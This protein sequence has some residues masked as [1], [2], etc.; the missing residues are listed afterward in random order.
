MKLNAPKNQTNDFGKYK[1]RSCE[2][3]YEGLKKVLPGTGLV[4]TV[5]DDL[6]IEP[7]ATDP[8]KLI[9][10]IKAVA[11][12][13]DGSEKNSLSSTSFAQVDQHKG[14][15]AE[16]TFG[17]ASSYARKYALSGLF[18]IDDNKDADSTEVTKNDA[19]K[20]NTPTKQPA[21]NVV[22]NK[23]NIQ[24]P[25]SA[26]TQKPASAP[27]QKPASAP[28]QKP[29][30][31]PTKSKDEAK[32]AKKPTLDKELVAKAKKLGIAADKLAAFLKK[33]PNELTDADLL[34]AVNAKEQE[35]AK[36]PQE[37]KK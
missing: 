15:S 16:Q 22:Q 13:S 20:S 23:N 34:Y 24:K 11:T 32:N 30:N 12:V 6:V 31:N 19:V 1:Y 3:I 28:A 14:M 33:K 9:F 25:A 17:T 36:K 21:K 35:L 10:I 5:S 29:A 2:D 27:A 18:M 7:S 26:P 8:N 37:T 4:V